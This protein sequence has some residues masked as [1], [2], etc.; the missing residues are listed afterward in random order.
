[1]LSQARPR[2]S[3]AV[4]GKRMGPPLPLPVTENNNSAFLTGT[5]KFNGDYTSELANTAQDR[6]NLR[7]H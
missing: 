4:P 6:G 1:M 2:A 3:P 7:K 5:I